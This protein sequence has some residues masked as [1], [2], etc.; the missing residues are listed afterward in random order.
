MICWPASPTPGSR[1]RPAGPAQAYQRTS[2]DADALQGLYQRGYAAQSQYDQ[3]RGSAQDARSVYD[4]ARDA[5]SRLQVRAPFAATVARR[6]LRLGQVASPGAPAFSLVDLSQL[7]VEVH[8]PERELARLSEGMPVEIRSEFQGDS[9]TMGEVIRVAPV[10]DA[11]TGTVKVTIGLDPEQRALRPGMFVNVRIIVETREDAVLI[12]KR[13]LTYEQGRPFVVVVR[14]G[15]AVR[16]PADVGFAGVEEV[17]LLRRGGA[18]RAHRGGRPDRPRRRRPRR[19]HRGRGARGARRWGAR[20]R[21]GSRRSHRRPGRRRGVIP[22]SAGGDD[23]T[24]GGMITRP[25]AVCMAVL[26]AVVFGL[27]S[28]RQLPLNL[29]PD[30]SYPTLT[31]RSD[32]EGAA[33]E[34]VESQ[35]S[36]LL[37]EALS[38]VPGLVDIESVSRAGEADIILEFQWGT[39]MDEVAQTVRER[40]A[41]ARLPDEATRPLLLRYDPA[42]DPILQIA[43]AGDQDQFA[44]R[45]LAEEEVRRALETL[46]GVAA[47]RVQGGL[48][49]ELRVEVSEALLQRRGFTLADIINRLAQ[50]N[51]NI[52]GGSLKEGETEYLIR[53]LNELTDAGEIS[54]LQVM[55]GEGDVRRLDELAVVRPAEREREVVSRVNGRPAVEIAVYKEADAN[56]VEV[57]RLVRLQLFGDGSRREPPSAEEVAAE[58]AAAEARAAASSGGGGP[59]GMGGGGPRRASRSAYVFGNLPD[60][61]DLRL[62]RDSSHFIEA[63]ISEVRSTAMWGGVLAVL[64]LFVFLRDLRSTGIIALSIPISIAVTFAPMFLFGVSLNLMSLGGLALAIGMLV[65]NSVVVLESIVRCREEGDDRLAGAVRGAREVAGAVTASTLTTVAVF[66]P[67]VFVEGIAGQLFGNLALTVVFGLLASLVVALFLIPTLSALQGDLGSMV[68]TA[69]AA[70]PRRPFAW[71]RGVAGDLKGGWVESWRWLRGG[72]GPQGWVRGAALPVLAI[73]Q[74]LRSLLL[75]AALFWGGLGTLAFAV[76]GFVL[77]RGWAVARRL[78]AGPSSRF[79]ES[80]DRGFAKLNTRYRALLTGAL[81]HPSRVLVPAVGLFLLSLLILPRLGSELLPDLAQGEFQVEV[82]L[83]VGTPLSSTEA[84]LPELER[85]AQAAPGVASVYAVAG[86]AEADQANSDRGEHTAVLQV[87]LA[88][89]GDPIEVEERAQAHLRDALARVPGLESVRIERPDL[90]SFRTPVEIEIRGHDLAA[91]RAQTELVVEELEGL[92]ELRDISSNLRSGYPSCTSPTTA[93]G[94]RPGGSTSPRWRRPCATR[95]RAASPRTWPAPPAAPTCES[96]PAR[97]TAPPWRACGA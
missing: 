16:M 26:A 62:I 2:E 82:Q 40:L 63:S 10:V 88:D 28:A 19:D 13:A 77:T 8:L 87:V 64:V 48:E 24:L 65:D 61:V 69:G 78:L 79:F 7:R 50:E 96:S 44:L 33:P 5:S 3:A 22:V 59:P 72:E 11:R 66:L 68:D 31:V 53:T 32:Y 27:V 35:V 39:D 81:A 1:P 92:G 36:R 49:R 20:S 73:Y 41:I 17:E 15:A 37:E 4:Q 9:T 38:T 83:P 34:E 25:V 80:F 56:I 94:W 30:L 57:A 54:A 71:M 76:A 47:V 58:E 45:E 21:G 6:D 67:L 85:I 70:E 51:V 86:V 18:R 95:C 75:V 84:L 89:E 60:D 97:R 91:L 52:A 29:M 42:L 74:A 23:S 43:L 46:P 90:F 14:E 93:S 55:N 12:D